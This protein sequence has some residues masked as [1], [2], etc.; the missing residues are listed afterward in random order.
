MHFYKISRAA[1]DDRSRPSRLAPSPGRHFHSGGIKAIR[2][3]GYQ[4]EI[5]SWGFKGAILFCEREWPLFFTA[6]R[7]AAFFARKI[8]RACIRL[9]NKTGAAGFG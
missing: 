2:A 3:R 5:F 7:C 6:A 8:L 4:R 1:A 9:C